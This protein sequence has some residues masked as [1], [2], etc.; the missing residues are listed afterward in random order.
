MREPWPV[1]SACH[2]GVGLYEERLNLGVL[3]GEGPRNCPFELD[4]DRLLGADHA[5]ALARRTGPAHDSRTPSSGVAG[6][7]HLHEAEL[8]RSPP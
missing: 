6:A 2:V 5:L 3:G 1:N 4:R 7:R 8:P